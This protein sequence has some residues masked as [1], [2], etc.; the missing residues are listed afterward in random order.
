MA[1]GVPLVSL[2]VPVVA[3]GCF[4]SGSRVS[5]KWLWGIPLVTLGIPLVALGYKFSG[6]GSTSGSSEK[7]L[8]TNNN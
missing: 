5:L 4:F 8:V 3:L 1:L 7:K 6:S 2:G